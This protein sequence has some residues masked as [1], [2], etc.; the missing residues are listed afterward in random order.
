MVSRRGGY[1]VNFDK[2]T[3][4]GKPEPISKSGLEEYRFFKCRLLLRCPSSS[5]AVDG[6]VAENA[7]KNCTGIAV[8]Y[9]I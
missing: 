2:I 5:L 6:S 3:K 9:Y 8:K 7:L 1:D 4:K